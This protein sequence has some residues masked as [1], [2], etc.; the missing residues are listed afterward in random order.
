MHARTL[1]ALALAL[2]LTTAGVGDALAQERDWQREVDTLLSRWSDVEGGRRLA[3][4]V[5][6]L[7][8]HLRVQGADPAARLE[9]ARVELARDNCRAALLAADQALEGFAQRL[10]GADDEAG[11]EVLER[12][13]QQRLRAL[14]LGFLA[15][16][17]EVQQGLDRISDSADS[18]AFLRD[19]GPQVA[20][21]RQALVEAAGDDEQVKA[22]L[23]AE[24]DHREALRQ[25]ERLG[26]APRP[27]GQE[28]LTGKPVDFTRY[29]GQVVLV[30]FW[31]A[32]APTGEGDVV[33]P[34]VAAVV[35]EVNA[36]QRELADRLF[37]VVG[38]NLDRER[39]TFDTFV[40]EHGLEGWRHLHSGEGWANGDAQAW[41]V[42]RVPT[43]YL[44]DHTG[45]VRYVDPW[46][47]NLR[48]RIDDLL[49][50]RDE[51]RR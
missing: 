35:D 5:E 22:V 10:E 17:Y 23:T 33:L 11:D 27:L 12:L 38:V 34:E 8:R 42:R 32:K 4:A 28:D 40:A 15:A 48:L 50:R 25:L 39:E 51:D 16:N 26:V 7:G 3:R 44:I 18:E 49:T 20:A 43:G 9:L 36:L 19:R 41:G 1:K 47:P 13:R 29:G 21:R 45:R 30:V 37:V 6:I 24:K 46:G 14:A 2:A 31:S